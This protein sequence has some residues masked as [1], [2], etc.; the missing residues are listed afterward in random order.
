LTRKQ[1]HEQGLAFYFTGR[2]CKNGHTDQRYTSTRQC[3][4]CK[5]NWS[6]EYAPTQLEQH[7]YRPGFRLHCAQCGVEVIFAG[8]VKGL[9]GAPACRITDSYKERNFC[10]KSCVDKHYVKRADI[11][12]RV[13]ERYA[14]DPEYREK[15]LAVQ[16]AQ[17]SRPDYRNKFRSYY[18]DW[19]ARN[20]DSQREY[21]REYLN[22]RRKAEI[23]FRL[24]MALSH[25][26]RQAIKHGYRSASTLELIGCSIDEVRAHL[27]AQ[28]QPGMTWDNWTIHGW[29]IDHIRPCAS[30]DL[31]DPEQQRGCFHYTNLQPLWASENCAKGDR[32][33][34]PLSGLSAASS[35]A[36]GR[37]GTA[38]GRRSQVH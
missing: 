17:R 19:S 37:N 7:Q 20:S 34:W 12:G 10:G 13:K 11:A 31:V 8:S 4:T 30:F 3:V 1:A 9:D 29:H 18:R 26:V 36:P 27:E 6:H 28:F 32:L 22:R 21:R 33:D 16:R 2:P 35:P 5:R 23:A 25:R 38:W 14:S 24:K 15:I